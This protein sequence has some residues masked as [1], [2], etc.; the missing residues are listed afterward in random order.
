MGLLDD[1]APCRGGCSWTVHFFFGRRGNNPYCHHRALAHD[2]QGRRELLT[3]ER[4]APG[5]PFD[6]GIF[7]SVEDAAGAPWPAED[8]LRLRTEQIQWE[9]RASQADPRDFVVVR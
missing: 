7:R 9:R 3:L 8:R 2:A 4:S 5:E 6:H 1:A